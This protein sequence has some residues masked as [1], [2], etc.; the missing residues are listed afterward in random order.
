VKGKGFK[1]SPLSPAERDVMDGVK[2][3]KGMGSAMREGDGSVPPSEMTME[4][5]RLS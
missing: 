4:D 2:R 1:S 5:D 3:N